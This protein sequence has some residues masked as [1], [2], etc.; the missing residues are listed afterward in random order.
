MRTPRTAATIAAGTILLPF[1]L[2]TGPA[3]AAGAEGNLILI[4]GALNE[5]AQ[6]LQRIVA[7]ADPDGSGPARARIAVVT[8]ASVPAATAAEAGDPAQS[9]AAANG[10]YYGDLFEQYGADAY[11]VPIDIETN[12]AGDPYVPGNAYSTTVADQVRA[13]TGVFFSGGDQS[14]YVE[15][16]L[17]CAPAAGDAFTDCVDTPVLGAV[18][19]VL[20]AGGVVAGSSAGLTIQNGAD[21]VTGG[22]SYEAWRYGAYAGTG[23]GADDLTY[24]PFGGFAFFTEGLL[25]SHFGT[26]GRQAR[27][28]ALADETGHDLVVG[29]DETTALVYDRATRRGEVIGVN[30]VS[31]LDLYGA[32]ITGDRAEYVRWDYLVNGDR[33]DF[34]TLA[35]TASA[36]KRSGA[37]TGSGP[38]LKRD[39]WDS[40]AGSGGTYSM[41]AQAKALVKSSADVAQG[42]TWERNPRYRTYLDRV[43]AT[44]WWSTGGFEGLEVSFIR[45]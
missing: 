15:T 8:A 6:I 26:W 44:R 13:S 40:P 45:E 16:L 31:I 36:T 7:D 27:M 9:N 17:D 23:V 11:L 19:S 34:S 32:A 24:S 39:I 35:V 18:R 41:V 22:E 4:G 3:H 33:I 37:G 2:G 10:L 29:V 25:D 42:T 5:N 12:Y 1:M 38:N 21:M 20:D 28:I 30:G 43:S 14:R